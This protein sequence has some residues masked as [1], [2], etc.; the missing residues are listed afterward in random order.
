MAS[1]RCR[2][3]AFFS[4][5]AVPA[6]GLKGQPKHGLSSRLGQPRP[7]CLRAGPGLD[8]AKISGHGP[9]HHASG[10]M[11]IY[12]PGMGTH[13]SGTW[14][15]APYHVPG[16]YAQR[17]KGPLSAAQRLMGLCGADMDARQDGLSV[18]IA[19]LS[20][21]GRPTCQPSLQQ[22]TCLLAPAMPIA[23][24]HVYPLF[25]PT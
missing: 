7:A 21:I 24:L 13:V 17:P 20:A 4:G 22:P 16:D 1:G 6:H 11:E 23:L 10:C 15:V 2:A 3:V 12:I 14:N 18:P 19:F 8:R 9:G 5:R 25:C